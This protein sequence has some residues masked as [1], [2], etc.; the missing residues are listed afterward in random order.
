MRSQKKENE[1][2]LFITCLVDNFFPEVGE[3]MLR[4][5]SKMGMNVEFPK[6]QTC[7]AQPAFNSGHRKE[8]GKVARHFLDVFA[9][10]DKAIVCPSGSCVS[11]VKNYY[12]EILRDDPERLS[13]A[14][15]VSSRIYEFS[16]F[17]YS[18]KET[19]RLES[20]YRGKVT[21]HDSCH[22][23]RELGI[24]SQPREIIRS[25][26][27]VELVEMNMPDA[28]C[29]FGGT[30]SI[31]YPEVSKSMLKEKTDSILDSGADAVVSTDMGC[32]MNIKGL[33][34]R[35]KM[36]V[37]VLHLAELIAFEDTK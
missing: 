28:C 32:L 27:G 22:A 7:C 14:K 9:R 16:E 30:F 5:L 17:I 19:F 13:R 1:I 24:S 26:D 34:S 29:G 23:L 33:V 31:K 6:N 2:L 12:A 15:E 35:K 20:R 8:A 36:P 3:A 37:K 18:R 11:M 21:F 4:V 25:L 10:S